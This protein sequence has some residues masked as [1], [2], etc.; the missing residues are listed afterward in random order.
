MEPGQLQFA[1]PTKVLDL[2]QS[3]FTEV[4]PPFG[5]Y[6]VGADGQRFVMLQQSNES[7]ATNRA[8]VLL[9][10]NWFEEHRSR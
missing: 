10:E 1:E 9:V 5:W 6:D 8:N 3:V 2:P 4:G 7:G